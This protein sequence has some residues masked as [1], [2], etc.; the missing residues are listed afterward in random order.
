MADQNKVLKKVNNR[1]LVDLKELPLEERRI[2]FEF[3]EFLKRKQK[4]GKK[5][6]VKKIKFQEWNLN[7]KSKLTRKEIYGSL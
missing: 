7:T 6:K 4:E 3:I 5:G 1:S 2:L